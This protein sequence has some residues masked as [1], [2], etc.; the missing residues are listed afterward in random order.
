[1]ASQADNHF[2]TV[3]RKGVGL[4]AVLFEIPV[5]DLFAAQVRRYQES[6]DALELYE[7]QEQA[8]DWAGP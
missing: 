3:T 8:R 7:L 5:S 1:M 6:F 2:V 4:N